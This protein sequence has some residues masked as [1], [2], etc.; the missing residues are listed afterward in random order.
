M[1]LP[2]SCRSRVTFCSRGMP[3]GFR[4]QASAPS[5]SGFF[6]TSL[7][8][9]RRRGGRA[10]Q[11]VP[12]S[13][14][15]PGHSVRFRRAWRA[16]VDSSREFCEAAPLD[17]DSRTRNTVRSDV[18]SWELLRGPLLGVASTLPRELGSR[19]EARFASWRVHSRVGDVVFEGECLVDRSNSWL[20]NTRNENTANR[21][22]R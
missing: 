4:L 12:C 9:R 14:S 17:R 22:W 19:V 1:K 11:S 15:V 18:A 20:A 2:I 16:V 21:D 10:R 7:P 5:A 8:R 6:S 3:I 13:L